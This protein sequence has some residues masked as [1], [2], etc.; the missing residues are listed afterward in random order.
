MICQ[1]FPTQETDSHQTST[2]GW[3]FCSSLVP[4]VP[5]SGLAK[6]KISCKAVKCLGKEQMKVI[7]MMAL[8]SEDDKALQLFWT[9]S[10]ESSHLTLVF[11]FINPKPSL[12]SEGMWLSYLLEVTNLMCFFSFFFV[13][14]GEQ[15]VLEEDR[16]SER[17]GLVPISHW[18]IVDS[19]INIK[20]AF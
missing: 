14:I 19:V 11:Y 5:H 13:D 1:P 6:K 18:Y 3:Q 17:I 8:A 7:D 10:A 20:T 4:D 16:I 15:K 12:C 9:H 2:V